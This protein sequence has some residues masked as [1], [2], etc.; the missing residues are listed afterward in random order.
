MKEMKEFLIILGVAGVE[1]AKVEA[2][3][4]VEDEDEAEG[5]EEEEEEEV[6]DCR[7]VVELIKVNYLFGMIC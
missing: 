6:E 3:G 7:M 5:G 2:G 4:E 1:E